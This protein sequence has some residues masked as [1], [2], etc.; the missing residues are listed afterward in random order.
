[1][2]TRMVIAIL[3]SSVL[4]SCGKNSSTNNTPHDDRPGDHSIPPDTTTIDQIVNFCSKL[5]FS[6]MRVPV[7]ATV[8]QINA[9]ALALNIS[10]SFEGNE[11]WKNITNNFD[12][13]GMS[14]GLLNQPLGTGSLQPLLISMHQRAPQTLKAQF[15]INRYTSLISM[16]NAWSSTVITPA[17]IDKLIYENNSP[18]NDLDYGEN[19]KI[20]ISSANASSV[21]WAVANLYQDVNGRVFKPEWKREFQALATTHQYRTIQME[22]SYRLHEKTLQYMNLFGFK[23]LNSYLF[24]FDIVVQNGGYYEQ[25]VRDFNNFIVSNPNASENQKLFALLQSRLVQVKNE[26]KEDVRLRKTAL[27]NGHGVVHGK[28]RNFRS[29]YCY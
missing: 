5:D 6:S 11:G 24:N 16:L 20:G 26:Y 27:I 10:G 4:L 13:Q 23:N 21:S 17:I 12:G 22:A 25:N 15:G 7:N 3:C 18:I 8:S 9:W 29:E 19:I 2:K 28:N 14:L 1:M